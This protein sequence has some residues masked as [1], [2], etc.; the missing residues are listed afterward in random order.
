MTVLDTTGETVERSAG[1]LAG[2]IGD[3]RRLFADGEL[4]LSGRWWDSL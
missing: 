1:S 2:W 3:Q 4:P